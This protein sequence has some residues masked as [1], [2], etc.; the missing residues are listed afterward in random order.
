MYIA[1]G[2]LCFKIY[3]N[4]TPLEMYYLKYFFVHDLR[5]VLIKTTLTKTTI[6]LEQ[7]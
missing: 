2:H 5:V 1:E 4:N 6:I 3:Q 7:L